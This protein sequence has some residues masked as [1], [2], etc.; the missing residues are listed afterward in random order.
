[1]SEADS[2]ANSKRAFT[3]FLKSYLFGLVLQYRPK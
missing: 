2:L 3:A 1:M